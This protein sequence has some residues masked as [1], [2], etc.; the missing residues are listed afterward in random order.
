MK[1]SKEALLE[2]AELFQSRN[3]N[4]YFKGGLARHG[5]GIMDDHIPFLKQGK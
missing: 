1:L 3:T 4:K 5:G 2:P